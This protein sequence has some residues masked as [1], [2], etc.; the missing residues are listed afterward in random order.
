MDLELSDDQVAPAATVLRPCSRAVSTRPD[1]CRPFDTPCGTSSAP[2]AC[3]RS[4]PTASAGPTASSCSSSWARLRA[5]PVGARAAWP[6]GRSAA[7]SVVVD[8]PH[9]GRGRARRAP[10]APRSSRRARRRRRLGDRRRRDRRGAVAVAARPAD[11]GHP[12]RGPSGRGAHRRLGPGREW[13]R[14]RK[15]S[16]RPSPS[17]SRSVVPSARGRPTPTRSSSTGR[18]ARSRR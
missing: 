5:R 15:R 11:S 17:V 18:S 8:R 6:T 4:V 10:R 9:P 14:R 16:R 1:P 2:R 3:S 13:R 12:R 7:P